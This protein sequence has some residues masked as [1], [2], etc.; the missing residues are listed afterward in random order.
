MTR[1]KSTKGACI[2]PFCRTKDRRYPLPCQK[3]KQAVRTH[4]HISYIEIH[5]SACLG[6][7]PGNPLIY[8]SMIAQKSH[9]KSAKKGKYWFI[10]RL[11]GRNSSSNQ[12]HCP[13]NRLKPAHVGLT[14]LFLLLFQQAKVHPPFW[15]SLPVRRDQ[16]FRT[17]Y[18]CFWVSPDKQKTLCTTNVPVLEI[19]LSL[20]FGLA[21]QRA[22][23]STSS[24]D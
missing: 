4:D 24:A 15:R 23:L 5:K 17:D 10:I 20:F 21:S 1:R 19:L 14:I 22:Y 16:G 6:I 9:K 12:W 2:H 11:L 8:K 13:P 18:F 3:E 7:L